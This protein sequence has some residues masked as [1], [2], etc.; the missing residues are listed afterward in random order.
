MRFT[1]ED[2]TKVFLVAIL[3][4]EDNGD[5]DEVNCKNANHWLE[6]SLWACVEC[7]NCP[8]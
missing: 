3:V 4:D 6:R 1:Q 5:D 8:A 7:E 2:G